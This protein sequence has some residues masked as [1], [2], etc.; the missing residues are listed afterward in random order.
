[1]EMPLYHWPNARTIG[2]SVWQH[3]LEF[4]KKAGSIIVAVST[5]VW[6]LSYLPGG[7][8]STSYLSMLGHWLA[9][10]GAW[11]GL[12]WRMV[13]ALLTS[14]VAKENTLATLGILY[15]TSR[16]SGGLAAALAGTL[17]PAAALAFLVI[18]MS[19]IPCV[20]TMAAI[21][22]ETRSWRWTAASAG[23]LLAASVSVGFTVYH[24]AYW[25]H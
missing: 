20:A 13:V 10:L 2:L 22:Q 15:E 25:W 14:I 18:Q 17:T 4:L 7:Q 6:A 1:M 12:D 24:L 11:V 23:I 3:V 9:P 8:M 19:F 16:Q 5:V 21:K